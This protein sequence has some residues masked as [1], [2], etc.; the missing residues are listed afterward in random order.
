MGLFSL[1][2]IIALAKAGYKPSDVKEL[3]QMDVP[4]NEQKAEP[5]APVDISGAEEKETKA[6]A[7][8]SGKDPEKAQDAPSKPA[9]VIDY[10]A[11]YEE[12]TAA[13]K[14]A[15]E[16]NTKKEAPKVPTD[17]FKDVDDY[18]RSLM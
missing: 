9:D 16:Q 14:K 7:E 8:N 11:K 18:L 6:P 3:M 1:S 12:A 2:D 15:Q 5:A 10:K 4:S 13:L 17:E